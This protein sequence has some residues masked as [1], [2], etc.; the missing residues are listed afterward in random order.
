[1]H[2]SKWFNSNV[3]SPSKLSFFMNPSSNFDKD[4]NLKIHLKSTKGK[5]LADNYINTLLKKEYF[6]QTNNYELRE[7]LRIRMMISKSFF[8]QGIV[9]NKLKLTWSAL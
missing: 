1:M 4:M 8:N 9:H 2:A 7:V 5:G 6:I 3:N